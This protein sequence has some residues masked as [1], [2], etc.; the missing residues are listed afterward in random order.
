MNVEKI[1][2][3]EFSKTEKKLRTGCPGVLN[4]MN[5][6]DIVKVESNNPIKTRNNFHSSAQ[7]LGIKISCKTTKTHTLVKRLS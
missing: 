1:S 5:V 7:F 2:D 4:K 3:E 6:G